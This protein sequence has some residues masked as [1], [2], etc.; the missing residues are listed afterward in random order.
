MQF[1]QFSVKYFFQNKVA[2]LLFHFKNKS[3]NAS[4]IFFFL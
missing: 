4:I 3:L 2:Y 1:K